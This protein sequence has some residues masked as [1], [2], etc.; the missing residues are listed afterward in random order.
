MNRRHRASSELTCPPQ[1]FDLPIGDLSM[2]QEPTANGE[3]THPDHAL[4]SAVL[5]GLLE[6]IGERLE[7]IVS[8]ALGPTMD[9]LTDRVDEMAAGIHNRF[10]QLSRV[11]NVPRNVTF[12]ITDG[13]YLRA[14]RE[15]TDFKT[16]R[17]RKQPEIVAGSM[18]KR[19]LV[20]QVPTG[21]GKTLGF[22]LPAHRSLNPDG[23]CIVIAVP[24]K[25][26][27]EEMV[28]TLAE[29]GFD[30]ATFNPKV[31]S[32]GSATIFVG[33]YDDVFGGDGRKALQSMGKELSRLVIDEGHK[34]VLDAEWRWVLR[35][36][37]DMALLDCPKSIFS[38]TLGDG[39][40]EKLVEA[41][42]MS[43]FAM[44]E[45]ETLQPNLRFSIEY[46]GSVAVHDENLK[47][48]AV[49]IIRPF[50]DSI[51]E[52]EVAIVFLENRAGCEALA[53]LLG[54]KA[55]HSG[56][57]QE[58][59]SAVLKKVEK[60]EVRIVIA[61]SCLG[62]GA[63][64]G[65]KVGGVIQLGLPQSIHDWLQFGGRGGRMGELC[66]V[67]VVLPSGFEKDTDALEGDKEGIKGVKHMMDGILSGACVRWI[68][69]KFFDREGRTC[70]SYTQ[71]VAWC[72]NC[73]KEFS[74]CDVE[75]W[76]PLDVQNRLPTPASTLVPMSTP[77]P[78]VGAQSPWCFTPT[79]VYWPPMASM[80]LGGPG[81]LPSGPMYASPATDS[82]EEYGAV[83]SHRHQYP[84]VESAK[85]M[86]TKVTGISRPTTF[87]AR[88][89]LRH[90]RQGRNRGG[91][92]R[93]NVQR[94]KKVCLCCYVK[95]GE[96]LEDHRMRNFECPSGSES[97]AAVHDAGSYNR[98][99]PVY[100]K[101]AKGRA[102]TW[103]HCPMDTNVHP[104]QSRSD[105][106]TGMRDVVLPVVCLVW[107]FHK[108]AMMEFLEGCG[109]VVC[110]KRDF[111]GE[112][113]FR[114]WLTRNPL[115]VELSG[116]HNV[117]IIFEWFTNNVRPACP[118]DG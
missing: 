79:P 105:E 29:Q 67:K 75:K 13:R 7:T 31:T 16:W 64:L 44:I 8:A 70:T 102:C 116:W 60:G 85:A 46:T 47:R 48:L 6:Q 96:Q 28:G 104:W 61:T 111:A 3:P 36:A 100:L 103:C 108:E 56:M 94:L 112:V 50:V 86:K 53:A 25:A 62:S 21:A 42:H 82:A 11:H 69:S 15:A 87:D 84:Q 2:F 19:H 113:A 5:R 72:G 91:R 1:V 76:R 57:A 32:M 73:E 63:N 43:D 17:H 33:L 95:T 88:V 4:H 54:G 58:D 66:Q 26:T 90:D 9:A 77:T 107:W 99:D 37:K 93:A 55:F 10:D 71:E 115:G 12:P 20:V 14:L 74:G 68:H 24:F 52:Q 45:E 30:V 110:D 98:K 97:A 41:M 27:R 35:L 89:A 106:C 117:H 92:F 49:E 34:I 101:W 22:S 40:L 83:R 65:R 38:A 39:V 18:S 78:K 109:D 81:A 118:E 114:T 80:M 59:R 51:A 23:R